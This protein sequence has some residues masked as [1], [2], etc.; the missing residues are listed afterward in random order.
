MFDSALKQCVALFYRDIGTHTSARLAAMLENEEWEGLASL[1]ADP[2]QHCSA[3][4][5]FLEAQAVGFLKK[6]QDFP[7][8]ADLRKQ[9]ATEK[10]WDGERQCKRT[11]DRLFWYLPENRVFEPSPRV[12]AIAD[13][14][15]A[16][17][18][19]ITDWIGPRP[20]AL[21]EGK[22]G[23]GA[24]FTDKGSKTSIPHKISSN[25]SLTSDCVWFLPQWLGNQAGAALAA[26]SDGKL[27][28]VK[29][30]RFTTVPKTAH[31]DRAIAVEPSVNVFFQL[32]IGRA[33]KS[34]LRS[35]TGWDLKH[36]Q[37]IHRR[38][39]RESSVSKE[40]ATLDLSNASDTV[41]K[42]LVR[43]CLPHAWYEQL[44]D[45]RSKFT[46]IQEKWV[47]LEKFSSMGNGFTFELETLIFAAI[48]DVVSRKAGYVRGLGVD[49]FVYGDD[50]ICKDNIVPDVQAALNFCGLTLNGSKSFWGDSPFRESCGGD[51][52]SGSDVRPYSLTSA[53]KEPHEFIALSNGINKAICKSGILDYSIGRSCWRTVQSRF[54]PASI[55][56][57]RGPEALG[58]IVL[59]DREVDRWRT[60][61]RGQIRYLQVW[62][63]AK[64]RIVRYGWFPDEVILACATYGTGGSRQ[65]GVIPRDG[66]I[67]YKLGWV[68]YS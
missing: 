10:W 5:Y 24:T 51:Y 39:A 37:E 14:L 19:T 47:Y 30:N 23:P 25:P 50:I 20:P 32:G 3:V 16:V 68:T 7:G 40:F 55:R 28:F 46:Q 2:R 18:K 49:Y 6:F 58:D 26:R 34:R 21:L 43:L 52:W 45:L 66:V 12:P 53:P 48:V 4:S 60:R 61:L 62:R 29:G 17:R 27:C 13:F 56:R 31:T 22:F 64:H 36:A 41:S 67:S 15:S 33:L 35:S 11:N 1:S 8:S 63:P 42:S 65:G 59:H 54:I 57:C 9:R 38:I 44:D